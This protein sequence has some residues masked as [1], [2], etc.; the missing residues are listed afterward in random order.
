MTSRKIDLMITAIKNQNDY[1]FKELEEKERINK[2][3]HN[4][5]NKIIKKVRREIINHTND[6]INTNNNDDFLTKDPL[7]SIEYN[8]KP[9]IP[10]IKDDIYNYINKYNFNRKPMLN[11]NWRNRIKI[12]K[13]MD[14]KLNIYTLN[15]NKYID[16][17]KKK[18][19]QRNDLNRKKTK[20][21]L[22]QIKQSNNELKKEIILKQAKQFN[23]FIN[24][25]KK[26]NL[27]YKKYN[28]VL[29][30]K[31]KLAKDRYNINITKKLKTIKTSLF[32][33]KKKLNN[34]NIK[35]INIE[36]IK[37]KLFLNKQKIKE[38]N[39]KN[40]EKIIEKEN[41][42]FLKAKNKEDKINEGK[43]NALI[44]EKNNIKQNELKL[45]EAKQIIDKIL[46]KEIIYK[47]DKN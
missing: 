6:I 20:M 34:K 47:K 10:V 8:S 15:K 18:F 5:K 4:Y 36:D 26:K 41:K 9:L 42:Y 43:I 32:N 27:D 2:N 28:E 17:I 46:K 13:S 21:I 38:N 30:N 24:Y 31:I 7:E 39:E 29:N 23:N 40:K 44:K 25:L 12:N 35:T 14:A 22:E 33:N 11:K 1:D 19:S 45:T 37:R 16:D 3:I